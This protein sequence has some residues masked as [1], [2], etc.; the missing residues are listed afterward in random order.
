M[1]ANWKHFYKPHSLDNT[2]STTVAVL[3]HIILNHTVHMCILT[4]RNCCL[5]LNY[6]F[7]TPNGTSYITTSKLN[8]YKKG[9]LCA[10]FQLFLT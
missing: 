5:Y 9:A 3:L 1:K 8:N 6:Q 4:A 10:K 7:C 2:L